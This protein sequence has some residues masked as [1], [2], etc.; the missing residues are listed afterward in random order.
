[1]LQREEY[2]EKFNDIMNGNEMADKLAKEGTKIFQ[3]LEIPKFKDKF[4]L[5]NK[6]DQVIY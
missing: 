2:K 4:F 6:D 5:F 3:K 1:M